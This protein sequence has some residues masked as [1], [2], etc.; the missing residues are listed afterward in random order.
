M[1]GNHNDLLHTLQAE[2]DRLRSENQQLQQNLRTNPDEG[3]F[4][5]MFLENN[6]VQLVIDP[7]TGNIQEANFAACNFYG[8]SLDEFKTLNIR[9]LNQLSAEQIESRL[10]E[11]KIRK[12]NYF[13]FQHRLANGEIREVEV[14]STPVKYQAK[15]YLFSIIHDITERVQNKQALYQSEERYRKLS[16][17]TFEGIIIHEE[18]MIV[19]A[20][21][22]LMEMLELDYQDIVGKPVLDFV[23]PESR[24]K[25]LFYLKQHRTRTHEVNLLTPSGKK[26]FVE[27]EARWL[28]KEGQFIRVVAMR[29]ITERKKA[30]LELQNIYHRQKIIM[31]TVP[32]GIAFMDDH[33]FVVLNLAVC[34]IF[35]YRSDELINQNVKILYAKD[36]TFEYIDQTAYPMI[37]RGKTFKDEC[38]M[39]RK[40][41][42]VFWCEITG[43][44][45]SKEKDGSIWTF[46]DVNRRKKNELTLH[47]TYDNLKVS[48]KAIKEQN[49][50]LEKAYDKLQNAQSQLV[51]A[52]KMASLGQLTA[53]IAHEINNPLNFIYAGAEALQYNLE[54]FYEIFTLYQTLNPENYEQVKT[55]INELIQEYDP[56][57]DFKKEF[58]SLLDDIQ[59]GAN[60]MSDIVKSLRIFTRRD[61][62]VLKKADI[63]ENLEATL[64]LLHRRYEEAQI[65]IDKQYDTEIPA[66]ECYFSKLNQVFVNILNNAIEAHSTQIRIITKIYPPDYVQVTFEDDG[67]GIP[68]N[69][70]EKI[71]EPFFSTKD[72]HKGLGLSMAYEIM[73]EH[74]GFID[75]ESEPQKGTTFSLH[76]PI[77][78]SKI[79]KQ[80]GKQI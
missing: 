38:L 60:R 69:I 5:D 56:D 25:V 40:N 55:K 8:Y 36:K 30:Q 43:R 16:E 42:D 37:A 75:L 17:F 66:L 71:F 78:L 74:E 29:N 59:S 76:I 7:K 68:K 67:K 24:R 51:Q 48:E 13:H 4:R 73:Q 52:E 26:L 39:M 10:Q 47:R 32:I 31:D 61:E 41:G 2:V 77:G 33:K 79:L 80:K 23:A 11:A 14:Y 6:A 34:N 46:E 3:L 27:L 44:R 64:L 70:Q 63:H 12:R 45:V 28:K 53:G 20:N 22:T 18:E 57:F 50:A 19:D 49:L 21:S 1:S 58:L 15:E 9:Q 35:Q 65:K 62:A 72:K 54:D